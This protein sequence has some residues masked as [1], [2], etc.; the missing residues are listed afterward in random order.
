MSTQCNKSTISPLAEDVKELTREQLASMMAYGIAKSKLRERLA[1]L[2]VECPNCQD[3]QVQLLDCELQT[4]KCRSC[5]F[6]FSTH[7]IIGEE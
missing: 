1:V 7:F 4:W 6:P 5:H 3:P 2:D